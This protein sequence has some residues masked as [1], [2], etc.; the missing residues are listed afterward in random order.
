MINEI[1]EKVE[2][3]KSRAKHAL[4]QIKDWGKFD[5]EVFE[6]FEKI[7]TIDTFSIV[8]KDR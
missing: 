1:I 4:L 8:Y 7:K 3:H 2:L 6:D 5:S